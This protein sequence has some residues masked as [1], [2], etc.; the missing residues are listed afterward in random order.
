[1]KLWQMIRMDNIRD[2]N[3]RIEERLKD[4]VSLLRRPTARDLRSP[5]AEFP[6]VYMELVKKGWIG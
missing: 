4:H 5:V 2:R 3:A 6:R 1:M